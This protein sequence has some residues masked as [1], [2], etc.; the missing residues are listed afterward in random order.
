M[1]FWNGLPEQL[2]TAI[3]GALLLIIGAATELA[4][5]WLEALRNASGA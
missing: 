3:I 5:A 1:N 4:V 2:R